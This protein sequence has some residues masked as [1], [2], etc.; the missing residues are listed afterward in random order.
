MSRQRR[1]PWEV[2][3]QWLA[4]ALSLAILDCDGGRQLVGWETADG[5]EG[6]TYLP[7]YGGSPY[8]RR[9]P[10]APVS[11]PESW[12]VS[13]WMQNPVNAARFRDAGI[14]LFVGLWNGP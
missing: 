2:S 13:V 6:D 1:R 11:G 14:N 9:W 12:I 7:W 4:I 8:Y 3:A 5:G 10:N